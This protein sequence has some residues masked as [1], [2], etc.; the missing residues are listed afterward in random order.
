MLKE[1]VRKIRKENSSFGSGFEFWADLRFRAHI[2][3]LVS[4]LVIILVIILII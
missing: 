1:R 2:S 4:I 3:I